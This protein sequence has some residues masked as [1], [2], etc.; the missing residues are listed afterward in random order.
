[1]KDQW[2]F[3][4]ISMKLKTFFNI[5]ICDQNKILENKNQICAS[6]FYLNPFAVIVFTAKGGSKFQVV[7]VLL[8]KN[9]PLIFQV[10]NISVAIGVSLI[11]IH[12]PF[13]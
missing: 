5:K 8:G 4:E 10:L 12:S 9:F 1:M 3:N 7:A 6:S 2:N 11:I 13:L